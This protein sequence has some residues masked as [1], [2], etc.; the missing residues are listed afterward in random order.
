MKHSPIL[1]VR[2]RRLENSLMHI[3]IEFLSLDTGVHALESMFL[4]RLH[5]DVFGHFESVVKK[6]QVF[7]FFDEFFAWHVGECPV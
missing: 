3:R 6:H 7:V 1:L 4:E 2:L 5:Q